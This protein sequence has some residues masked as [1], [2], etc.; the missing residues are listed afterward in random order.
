MIESLEEAISANIDESVGLYNTE[1]VKE[2]AVDA[3]DRKII[4]Q[5]GKLLPQAMQDATTKQLT[6]FMGNVKK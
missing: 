5:V 4:E 1:A 2:L 6:N 3:D